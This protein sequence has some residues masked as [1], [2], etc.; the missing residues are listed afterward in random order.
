MQKN[1]LK[2]LKI[3]LVFK[4]QFSFSLSQNKA[5]APGTIKNTKNLLNSATQSSNFS[6]CDNMP[7]GI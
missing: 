1:P 3:M 7:G 6:H 2:T 4:A 5:K